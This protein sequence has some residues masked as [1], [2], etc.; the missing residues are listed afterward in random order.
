[1]R[2]GDAEIVSIAA[3]RPLESLIK[4]V[5]IVAVEA[6][7]VR[8]LRILSEEVG[9]FNYAGGFL[10]AVEWRRRRSDDFAVAVAKARRIVF[11]D[12]DERRFL[13]KDIDACDVYFVKISS[14]PCPEDFKR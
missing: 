5:V 6:T 10:V 3:F 9:D 11:R 4:L 14:H 12:F 2:L 1:M 13:E 8:T 7:P